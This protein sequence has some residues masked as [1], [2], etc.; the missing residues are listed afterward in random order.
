V[1]L[2]VFLLFSYDSKQSCFFSALVTIEAK[3]FSKV[4]FS[5]K[6][7]VEKEAQKQAVFLEKE[8]KIVFKED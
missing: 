2:P 7:K 1:F 4:E 5:V 6:A 3:F 8:V